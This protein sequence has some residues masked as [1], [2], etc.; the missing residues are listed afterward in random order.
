MT[1]TRRNPAWPML[2]YASMR[3]TLR[4][5]RANR[6]PTT[7]VAAASH[8]SARCHRSE[9]GPTASRQTRSS[10]AK[11]AALTAHAMKPEYGA[12]APS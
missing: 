12:G 11:E 10:A 7:I 9:P 8:Q 1:A 3:F 2:E 6:L 4:C 5:C